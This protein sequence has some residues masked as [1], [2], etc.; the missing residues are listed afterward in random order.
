MYRMLIGKSIEVYVDD[1]LVK[2]REKADHLRHLAEAFDILRKF[3][4]KLNP[5]K[6][7]FG[8]SSSKFLGHL[9]SR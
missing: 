7:A 1:L 9:I 4:M 5:A 2:S 3:Q 6:C 8:V